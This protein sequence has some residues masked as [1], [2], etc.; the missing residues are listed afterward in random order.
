MAERSVTFDLLARDRASKVFGNVASAAERSGGVLSKVGAAGVF[1]G[2][3]VL[4]VGVA[5]A[6][7]AGAGLKVGLETAAGMEQAQI[8]FSQLLGSQQKARKYMED[9]TSFAAKTP[10]EFPGL[11]DASRTLLGVGVAAKDVIPMLTNFGDAAGALGIKQDAFQR[12]MLA[13]AQAISAGKFQA[14]DLNQIMNNGLPIWSLLAKATGKPVPELRKLASEG[15]LLAKDV[16]PILQKQMQ[17]DYG[18][19]MEKQSRTLS[20]MWSTLM[21]TMSQGLASAI[22]P[23]IPV[24]SKV[25]PGAISALGGFFKWLA[26]AIAD[27]LPKLQAFAKAVGPHVQGALRAV[28]KAVSQLAGWIRDDLVPWV[29]QVADFVMP[30]FKGALDDV[31]AAFGNAEDGSNGMMAALKV[32]GGVLKIVVAAVIIAAAAFARNLAMQMRVT[33][34]VIDNVL[35]PAFRFMSNVFLGVVGAIVNG[36]AKAFGWMPGIGPKLRSAAAS[37]NAFRARVNAALSGIRSSKTITVRIRVNGNQSLLRVSDQEVNISSGRYSNRARHGGG[38][39]SPG[40]VYRVG[41]FGEETFVPDL[42]GRIV[43]N[44]KLGGKG[45][46]GTYNFHFHGAVGSRDEI[47][48]WVAEG[49]RRADRR[50]LGYAYGSG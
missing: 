7:L 35:I 46:G 32:L 6:G 30:L 20:G 4:G 27:G 19:A 8:A 40:T 43:P 9:L 14:G 15:K 25:M 18:G 28:G 23:L 29:K 47:I 31:K 24:L 44:H 2:K 36:A 48:R 12:I 3:A 26:K 11:V 16:L 34:G 39:V 37:F 10:F 38:R 17:K 21:D 1:I 45:S 49:M 41:E 22:Q 42:A 5:A 50:G 33:R 13:T